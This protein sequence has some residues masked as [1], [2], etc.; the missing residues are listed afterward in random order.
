MTLSFDECQ[1]VVFP[2]H[3]TLNT[4]KINNKEKKKEENSSKDV[5]VRWQKFPANRTI[6]LQ[7]KMHRPQQTQIFRLDSIAV[8]SSDS[9]RQF[10]PV[11]FR[12]C[13]TVAMSCSLKNQESSVHFGHTI[14]MVAFARKLWN[15]L[16]Y[17]LRALTRDFNYVTDQF[18]G[19]DGLVV[20]VLHI[21]KHF[22]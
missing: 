8:W 9:W 12:V 10:P 3:I 16:N 5:T 11:I 18:F 4:T 21:F 15:R 2:L 13:L 6:T 7:S 22:V 14:E 17:F 1:S 19:L 20:L